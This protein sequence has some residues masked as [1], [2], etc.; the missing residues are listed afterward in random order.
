MRFVSSTLVRP[1]ELTELDER[2]L[3]LDELLGQSNG[4]T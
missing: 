1:P 3:V 4:P 2:E